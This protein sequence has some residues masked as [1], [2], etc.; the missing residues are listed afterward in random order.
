MSES[1]KHKGGRPPVEFTKVERES[2][3]KF[4]AVGMPQEAIARALGKTIDSLRRHCMAE[5]ELGKWAW[6]GKTLLKLYELGHENG[7]VAAI[8]ELLVLQRASAADDAFNGSSAPRPKH[9]ERIGKKEAA[10][11]AAQTAGAGSE[12]GDD[13]DPDSVN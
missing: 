6:R 8:K 1:E 13:L 12:W 4:A 5:L 2:V 7:N 9:P 10:R 11:R 3:S